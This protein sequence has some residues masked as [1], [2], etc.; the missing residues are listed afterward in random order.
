METQ[1]FYS[2]EKP[3]DFTHIVDLQFM[4]AMIHPGGGRNDIPARLKRQFT[5]F[6]C[7]LPSDASIDKI[8][9]VIGCGY[10]CQQRGFTEEVCSTVAQL[11]P[12]TRLLWQKTKVNIAIF[13]FLTFLFYVYLGKNVAHSCKISLHFQFT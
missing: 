3:G 9:G 11:V 13:I 7:T 10:F 6:N 4:A 8:F 2:L 12:A 1:G 5:I